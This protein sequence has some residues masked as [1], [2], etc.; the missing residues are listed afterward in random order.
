MKNKEKTDWNI[1]AK[2]LA[3]ETDEQ[4][5][6]EI[7]A[8]LQESASNS[9]LYNEIIGYWNH[10]NSIKEM[11]QFDVNN[12]WEKLHNR[13][14]ASSGSHTT[15]KEEKSHGRRIWFNMPWLRVAAAIALIVMIGI[16][17]Y[18][19]VS[20]LQKNSLLTVASAA[21]DDQTRITL[22]DGSLVF[23]NAN[24]KISYSKKFS[25]GVRLVRLTGEAYFD[26]AHDP[27]RP[28]IVYAR[29]AGIK[30]LGTSFNVQSLKS[31]GKVEVFVESGKVQLFEADNTSNTITIEP[32]FIG[33]MEDATVEKQKNT[34]ENYLAW[35]TKKLTFKNTDM[36]KV[37]KGIQDVFKVDVVF[38]NPEMI[39]CKIESHFENESLEN[40]LDAICTLFT[41]KWERKGD[42]VILS[43][44]GC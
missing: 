25:S 3:G 9:I 30:V 31:S 11:N 8:W 7:S 12:G 14:I 41:W 40:V 18:F 34:D 32:G 16:G 20:G 22:P 37:A 13:I 23:L 24:T 39:R 21:T 36:A 28:F 10:I 35:K 27:E 4:G 1:L 6:K 44:A 26:V 43:G 2:H 5:Q 33:S 38:E 42:K 17:S 19:V 15:M 29:K